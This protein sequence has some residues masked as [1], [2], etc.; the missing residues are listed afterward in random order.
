MIAAFELRACAHAVLQDQGP[1]AL[2]FVTKRIGP[3]AV[4]GDV[5]GVETRKQIAHRL[6]QPMGTP[7]R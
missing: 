4:K 3:L 6:E 2:T 1:N 5:E 7:L